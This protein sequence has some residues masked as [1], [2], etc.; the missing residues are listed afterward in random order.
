MLQKNDQQSGAAGAGAGLP[1]RE[2]DGPEMGR[3][4]MVVFVMFWMF[5]GLLWGLG[6]GWLVW[7]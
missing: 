4:E 6:I 2:N 7:G 3:S 1:L 5:W